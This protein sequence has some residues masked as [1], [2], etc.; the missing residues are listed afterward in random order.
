MHE[1]DKAVLEGLVSVAWADGAFQ[2]R[3]KEMLE[4]LLE[5][6]GATHEE[7][8]DLRDYAAKKRD[9]KDIALTDLSA[10]DRRLLLQHAV[11]LSWVDGDQADSEVKFL[12]DLRD[13]LHIPQEEGD[14]LVA[15]S[16]ERAQNLLK[17]LKEEDDAAS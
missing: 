5:S 2:D 4:A 16:T 1:Q 12:N 7:A 9:M 8:T 13:Y 11:V 15:K 14:A 3:E 10:D 17:L 6:F